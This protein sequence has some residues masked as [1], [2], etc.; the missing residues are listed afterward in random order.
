MELGKAAFS[1]IEIYF[2]IEKFVYL[3]K[4]CGITEVQLTQRMSTPIK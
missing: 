3:G 1:E 2:Q 4:P